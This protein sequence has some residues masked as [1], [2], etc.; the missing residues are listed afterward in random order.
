MSK[1]THYKLKILIENCDYPYVEKVYLKLEKG[2]LSVVEKISLSKHNIPT[3]E[4]MTDK[5][6]ENI[7]K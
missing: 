3:L 5:E 1:E 7:P 2:K 4:E 6:I